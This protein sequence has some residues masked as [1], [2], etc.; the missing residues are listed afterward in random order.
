MTS[1]FH[2]PVLGPEAVAFLD[3]DGDGLYL[4]GTVGGGACAG[5]SGACRHSWR[6]TGIPKP[7]RR[8]GRG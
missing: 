5:L 4:D 2:V 7:C 6:W 1:S 3:P 8:R